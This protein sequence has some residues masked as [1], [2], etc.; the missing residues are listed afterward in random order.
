MRFVKLFPVVLLVTAVCAF[1]Q[2]DPSAAA[3]DTGAPL[4]PEMHSFDVNAM[5]KTANP[6]V[7]FY[8]FACGNWLKNNPVP[9]DKG[10]YGR[11]TE[12][13]ERN[14]AV[15]HN[16]LE[17]SAANDPK[18]SATEQKYGDYYASCMDEKGIDEKALAPL[19]PELDRIAALQNTKD[20]P[21][22]LAHEHTL[23]FGPLFF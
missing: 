1:S 7:D 5:D 12:L 8:Q 11:F 3:A 14:R 4:P 2:A 10:S 23:G 20:L 15:L 21:K 17:K 19:K 13:F 9:S 16:I 18:R 22:L 6:C